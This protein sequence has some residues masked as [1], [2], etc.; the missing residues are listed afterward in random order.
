MHDIAVVVPTVC[1]R[2]LLRAVTS[3][4]RQDFSGRIQILVGVDKDL[5]GKSAE[6]R[7]TLEKQLPQ[8]CSLLWFEPGYS[9][10]VRH[11]GVHKCTFGGALRTVLSFAADSPLVMYLDDDDWLAPQH[12]RL[13]VQAIADKSWA[14]SYCIYANGNQG[15]GLCPDYLESVGPDKGFFAAQG[16]FVRPSGMLVNKIKTADILHLWADSPNENGDGEDR[17]IFEKL[18]HKPY[19]ETSVATVY[20]ALDPRDGMHQQRLDYIARQG[21]MFNEVDKVGSVRENKSV[22]RI[23]WRRLTKKYLKRAICRI[24]GKV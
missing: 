13:I 14:F 9:T 21:M 6:L 20:Y 7:R 15:T 17:L 1:R 8:N 24:T 2:S 19:G 4:Y 3:I 18:R 10:S 11:G 5:T 12:C 16:G 22:F 23:L